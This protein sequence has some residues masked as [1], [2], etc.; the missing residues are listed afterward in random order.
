MFYC[1]IAVQSQSEILTLSTK[2]S[3]KGSCL[4][5]QVTLDVTEFDRDVVVCHCQQCR[6]Q[7]GHFLAATRAINTNLT[8]KGE[9]NL[10]WYQASQDAERGFCKHC[11]SALFWRQ[12]NSD[13][14]SIMAGCL[15]SPTGLK[16]DRHIFVDDKGDYYSIEPDAKTYA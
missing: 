15:E 3:N 7:T 16:I 9:E 12:L 6:K 2:Q 11:G 5:G 4:C 10:T 13:R 14:T 8:I 1:N